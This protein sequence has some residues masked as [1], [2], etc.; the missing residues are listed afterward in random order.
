MQKPKQTNLYKK[1][2]LFFI[3]IHKCFSYAFKMSQ[4]SSRKYLQ[5]NNGYKKPIQKK[6]KATTLSWTVYKNFPKDEKQGLVEYKKNIMKW[7]KMKM[8]LNKRL[9]DT[10]WILQAAPL[11]TTQ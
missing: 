6:K 11:S 2:F 8:L 1:L 9:V 4:Y 3:F 5:K 10:F 7:G